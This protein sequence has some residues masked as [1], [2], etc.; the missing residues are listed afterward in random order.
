MLGENSPLPSLVGMILSPCECMLSWFQ[1]F[2][3]PWI[4]A[5]QT[6]LSMRFPRQ[7]YWNGLLF[8]SPGDLPDPGIKLKSPALAGGFFTS[9]P[10]N[11]KCFQCCKTRL[12][13]P[14]LRA[15]MQMGG[16]GRKG[17]KSRALGQGK[18]TPQR[19]VAGACTVGLV[20]NWVLGH[21]LHLTVV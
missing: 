10:V 4:V 17:S 18:G 9:Q 15:A 12:L 19:N 14:G 20:C 1:L 7:E 16:V 5:H 11:M 13:P 2:V 8:L 6:P 21:R 3:T